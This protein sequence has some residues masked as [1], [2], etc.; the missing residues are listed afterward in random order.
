MSQMTPLPLVISRGDS[1]ASSRVAL[2]QRGG[3]ELLT[4]Q[5]RMRVD[6]AADRDQLVAVTG[7]PAVQLTG[8]RFYRSSPP[9]LARGNAASRCSL[10]MV[11]TTQPNLPLRRRRNY[12]RVVAGIVS[13]LLTLVPRFR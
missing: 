5:L 2:D 3:R 10:A 4:G 13:A 7:E 9:S 6:V 11:R 1:P 12:L 8:Q